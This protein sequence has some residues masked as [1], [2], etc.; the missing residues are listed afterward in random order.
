MNAQEGLNPNPPDFSTFGLEPCDGGQLIL[1]EVNGDDGGFVSGIFM[2]Y[3]NGRIGGLSA[4][5]RVG[6]DDA[7]H[8]ELDFLIERCGDGN[9][10]LEGLR[11]SCRDGSFAQMLVVDALAAGDA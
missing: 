7:E 1:V 8:T 3:P 11:K 2:Q 4:G 9:W 5:V 6:L 10:M